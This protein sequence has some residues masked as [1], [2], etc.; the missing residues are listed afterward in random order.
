[1]RQKILII[2]L[3][4]YI[5]T[6]FS[7]S[8]LDVV[9]ERVALSPR[10]EELLAKVLPYVSKISSE[11]LLVLAVMEQE[12]TYR[13][14]HGDSGKAIGFMQIH[15]D[16]AKYMAELYKDKLN[17]IGIVNLQF[18]SVQD[19][20]KTPIRTTLLGV[21]WLEHNIKHTKYIYTAISRYNGINNHEYVIKVLN[22]YYQ[23]IKIYEELIE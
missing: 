21:L 19:L 23:L 17:E 6:S 2:I 13:W 8:L 1:M 20:I 3:L 7:V 15:L 10:N 11:P 16:T 18:N 9:K 4:S 5:I 22:R 14:T 12:S